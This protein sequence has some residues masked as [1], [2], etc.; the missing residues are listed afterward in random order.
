MAVRSFG[1]REVTIGT[2]MDQLRLM[3]NSFVKSGNFEPGIKADWE[4]ATKEAVLKDPNMPLKLVSLPENIDGMRRMINEA[5]ATDDILKKFYPEHK[6]TN[7]Y[8]S[9]AD[10]PVSVDE[11]I[12]LY[13]QGNAQ[14]VTELTA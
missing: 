3:Q 12:G 13:R 8:L 10:K 4:F 2:A 6:K 1:G 7:E 5:G 14:K 9:G 11:A